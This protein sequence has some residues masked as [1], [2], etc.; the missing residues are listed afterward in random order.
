VLPWAWLN[1]KRS[2][3]DRLQ[4]RYDR[5]WSA[6]VED[7]K[8]GSIELDPVLAMGFP[9][10]RRGLT[11]MARPSRAV[12]QRV[13]AFLD[14]L[15]RLEPDQHYYA[16]SE[17]HVTI[18]SLF[19]ATVEHERFLARTE[20]YVAAVDSA[21]RRVP[22]IRM[23][24]D[25]LTASTGAIMIQGFCENEALNDGR[26]ALRRELRSGGFGEDIDG[27]YRL[28][29]A[30]ITVSRFRTHLRD[31][32]KYAAT[33]ERARRLPFGATNITSLSLVKNDWYMSRQNLWTIKR[34]RL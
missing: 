31:N 29:T 13:A 15:C 8:A 28:E 23:E 30:H 16:L 3:R 1:L 24:F 17:L 2:A 26:D 11:V 18:L 4:D 9:D 32:G 25:G 6:T 14:E 12:R 10:R 19:T 34:Y 20:Q 27:R 5:L 33:L 21:L 7:L 22:P